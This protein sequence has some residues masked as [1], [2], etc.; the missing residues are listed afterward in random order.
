MSDEEDTIGYSD[1]DKCGC[2]RKLH[3]QMKAEH[4]EESY[5]MLSLFLKTDDEGNMGQVHG[6][7]PLRFEYKE[8]RRWLKSHF[9]YQFCPFCGVKF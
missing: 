1:D 2:I 4:G 6:L 8:K 7:P 3:D 9:T 5:L